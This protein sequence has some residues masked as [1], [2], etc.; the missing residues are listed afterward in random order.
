[1]EQYNGVL[2]MEHACQAPGCKKFTVDPAPE[3]LDAC[4]LS[5]MDEGYHICKAVQ[6][7][8]KGSFGLEE[9]E[10]LM[11]S[12]LIQDMGVHATAQVLISEG[13]GPIAAS[14]CEPPE[15]FMYPE[16]PTPFHGVDWTTTCEE[17]GVKVGDDL[18]VVA[19][20]PDLQLG[21]ES[22][23]FIPENRKDRVPEDSMDTLHYK[24]VFSSFCH[25]LRQLR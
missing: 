2:V 15:G 24:Y 16:L 7:K 6:W 12:T 13:L 19:F 25:H 22:C 4:I 20:V 1:M 5:C 17:E 23:V 9:N 8:E 21:C 18:P 11:Y 3:D 14:F 10:C